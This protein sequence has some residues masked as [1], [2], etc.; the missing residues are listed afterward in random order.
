MNT[1]KLEN[2]LSDI[3]QMGNYDEYLNLFR[4][5]VKLHRKQFTEENLPTSEYEILTMVNKVLD[6]MWE[7][8]GYKRDMTVYQSFVNGGK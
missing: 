2:M 4:L 6:E 3:I 8:C 7:Y 5:I 1:N